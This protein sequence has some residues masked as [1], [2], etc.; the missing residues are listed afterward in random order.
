MDAKL[1]W[2]RGEGGSLENIEHLKAQQWFAMDDND[3]Q[4]WTVERVKLSRKEISNYQ[5]H[6]SVQ[7]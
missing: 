6:V 7:F 1:K 3:S 4:T 5:P 2:M